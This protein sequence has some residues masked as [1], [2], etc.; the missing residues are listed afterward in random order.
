MTGEVR[1]NVEL[2]NC[3]LC[4][5][6]N[7]VICRHSERFCLPLCW[8]QRQWSILRI[9][10][11]HTPDAEWQSA[12]NPK[13]IARI[14]IPTLP[15]ERV[16]QWIHQLNCSLWFRW[17]EQKL[18]VMRRLLTEWKGEECGNRL[19]IHCGRLPLLYGGEWELAHVDGSHL[20]EARHG[21][22]VRPRHRIP[23]AESQGRD[24]SFCIPTLLI[25]M[26]QNHQYRQQLQP[27]EQ[28]VPAGTKRFQFSV[29]FSGS[30]AD[31]SSVHLYTASSPDMLMK[32]LQ[33]PEKLLQLEAPWPADMPFL[34]IEHLPIVYES[35]R[36][37]RARLRDAIFQT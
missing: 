21:H 37:F 10:I 29:L 17:S 1:E 16:R 8:T 2:S 31:N 14:K 35:H 32:L 23:G 20:T 12:I 13:P 5:S 34:T 25:A 11:L 15:A 33:A 27:T 4:A 3:L 6:L 7:R 26:A 36:S 22:P 9:Q 28:T 24:S 19:E 18:E 30:E